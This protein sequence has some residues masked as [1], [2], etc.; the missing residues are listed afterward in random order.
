[1]DLQ[2][3]N[4]LAGYVEMTRNKQ[5][6]VVGYEKNIGKTKTFCDKIIWGI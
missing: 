3:L 1:M 2:E 4:G 6:W 5:I